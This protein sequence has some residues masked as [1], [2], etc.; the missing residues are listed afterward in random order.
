MAGKHIAE[1]LATAR[2]LR[3]PPIAFWVTSV[4]VALLALHF[5]GPF[6]I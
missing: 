3:V 5:T 6:G 2:K 1:P 4:V